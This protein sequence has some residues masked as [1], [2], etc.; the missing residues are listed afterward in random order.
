M[1]KL[2]TNRSITRH[3]KFNSEKNDTIWKVRS[4]QNNEIYHKWK[5]HHRVNF[6]SFLNSLNLMNCL[7]SKIIMTCGFYEIY[8]GKMCDKINSKYGIRVNKKIL[9]LSPSVIHECIIIISTLL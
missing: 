1:R 5:M 8:K 7:E 9:F 3:V 2:F 6:S 4:T